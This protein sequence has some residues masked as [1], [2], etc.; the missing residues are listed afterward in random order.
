MKIK[1]IIWFDDIIEKLDR[2]HNV[3]QHEVNEVLSNKPMFRYVEK[4]HH[5][6]EDVYAA[7]GHA[8]SGRYLI[9]FF[10]YKTDGRA[11][12]LSAREMTKSE[13][14]LYEKA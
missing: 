8:A 10:V 13:R 9:V 12:I 3:L 1:G 14:R 11:L 6:D 5:Q 4:G 2:K 7:M